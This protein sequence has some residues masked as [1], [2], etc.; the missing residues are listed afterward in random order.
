MSGVECRQNIATILLVP[1]LSAF[2]PRRAF[3]LV[4]LLVVIAVMGVLAALIVPVAGQVKIHQYRFNARAEME[5]LETAIERYKAAYGFYPPD[6]RK[7][8]S[9]STMPP[10]NQLYYELVGTVLTNSLAGSYYYTLDGAATI[11]TADVNNSFG[12]GG[13]MNCTKPNGSDESTVARNFLPD[14]KPNQIWPPPGGNLYTNNGVGIYMLRTSVGGPDPTYTP[15]GVQD[16][17]PWRYNSHSPTNNPGAYDLYVQL[18]IG[19]QTNLICNWSKSVEIN[20][21]SP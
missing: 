7:G 19:G 9:V 6:N 17:N 15:L 5:Q 16:L 20:V 1:R 11:T 12:V 8:S 13:F 4:E 10:V 3:T 21:P 2:D 14:L 18:R